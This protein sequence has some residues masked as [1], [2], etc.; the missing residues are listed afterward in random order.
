MLLYCSDS[1]LRHPMAPEWKRNCPCPKSC[2]I[3]SNE[4]LEKYTGTA[5]PM[6]TAANGMCYFKIRDSQDQ[7][8]DATLFTDKGIVIKFSKQRTIYTQAAKLFIAYM[9]VLANKIDASLP[10]FEAANPG[11][12]SGKLVKPDGRHFVA[13]DK[14]WAAHRC[15]VRSVGP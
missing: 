8:A 3:A 15:D 12:L 14:Y 4:R 9:V 5:S 2:L 1:G 10:V 6:H 13:M 7:V 11:D